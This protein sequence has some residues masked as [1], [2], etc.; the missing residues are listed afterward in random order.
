ML[1]SSSRTGQVLLL[2]GRVALGAV[3]LYAAFAKLRPVMPG[4]FT[5]DS[6]KL[7][8]S[9]FAMQVDSYQLLPSSAVTFIAN[10]LPFFELLIGLLLVIGWQ[11]RWVA[12]LTSLL[13]LG[14]FG[15]MVRSYALHLEINCGCFGPGE[16]LGPKTL[17]RDGSL[18]ALSLAVAIGAFW[19]RRMRSQTTGAVPGA[20]PHPENAE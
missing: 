10:S 5:L 4:P 13:L 18:L 3:F 12:S 2:I 15:T 19:S 6:L 20:A 1:R 11:L 17:I 14:F 7:S 9:M 16:A 8:L